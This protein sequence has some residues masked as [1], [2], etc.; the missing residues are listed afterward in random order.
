M[1]SL[2]GSPGSGLAKARVSGSEGPL[3]GPDSD[4][5]IDDTV[6]LHVKSNIRVYLLKSPI[7]DPHNEVVL[8]IVY[9]LLNFTKSEISELTDMRKLLPIYKIDEKSTKKA[10][11]NPNTDPRNNMSFGPKKEESKNAGAAP[12]KD[13]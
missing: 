11:K 3:S 1:D 9:S 12:S 2:L 10:L 5:P 4:Q 6:L 8:Q 13:E 7:I